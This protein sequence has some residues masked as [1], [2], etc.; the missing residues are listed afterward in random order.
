MTENI[1]LP[2]PLKGCDSASSSA[3]DPGGISDVRVAVRGGARTG[4]FLEIEG[5]IRDPIVRLSTGAATR[6][7]SPGEIKGPTQPSSGHVSSR[8][9]VIELVC[10]LDTADGLVGDTLDVIVEGWEPC[11]DRERRLVEHAL[12][13]E[14]GWNRPS[15]GQSGGGQARAARPGLNL[16]V[17]KVAL[18]EAQRRLTRAI[19]A[20]HAQVKGQEH[21]EENEQREGTHEEQPI[22]ARWV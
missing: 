16:G 6:N 12:G 15:V 5:R 4:E 1:S 21:D 7:I 8:V 10:R 11:R 14:L 18:A 2:Q 22:H 20:L 19:L 13:R 9:L 3:I 17:G